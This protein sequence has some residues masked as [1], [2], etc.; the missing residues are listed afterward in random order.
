MAPPTPS[1]LREAETSPNK[2]MQQIVSDQ[3]SRLG[4]CRDF[5][6]R[7]LDFADGEDIRLLSLYP[8]NFQDPIRCDIFH[9]SLQFE[10]EYEAVSYVHL[11]VVCVSCADF[12]SLP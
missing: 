11:G 10:I 4:R 9:A 1:R 12:S 2:K 6:Y 3:P 7:P 5:Y 8:G